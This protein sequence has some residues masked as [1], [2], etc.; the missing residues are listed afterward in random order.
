VV[1]KARLATTRSHLGKVPL[2]VC[3]ARHVALSELR[4]AFARAAGQDLT[5][6]REGDAEAVKRR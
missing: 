3:V 2:E 4:V 5:E 1:A 6:M